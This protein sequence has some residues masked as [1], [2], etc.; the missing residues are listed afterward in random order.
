MMQANAA[1][2]KKVI[3]ILTMLRD[4][5][6][7]NNLKGNGTIKE[8]K[9]KLQAILNDEEN[10]YVAIQ[11]PEEDVV[12]IEDAKLNAL[13]EAIGFLGESMTYP[14]Q[15]VKNIDNAVMKLKK[16]ID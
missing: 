14:K 7:L 4:E 5:V 11:A 3:E 2:V 1:E 15:I 10:R 8:A 13:F 9:S 16:C 12:A 6:M